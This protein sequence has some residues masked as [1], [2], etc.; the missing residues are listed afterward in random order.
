MF[1]T[2]LRLLLE[3]GSMVTVH[4][5]R[6][7]GKEVHRAG[8]F[9]WVRAADGSLEAGPD[10]EE[11]ARHSGGIWTGAGHPV[12][13]C[14][15]H[16]STCTARFESDN[17]D[18]STT[19]GPFDTVEFV[20]GSVYANPGC[21]LLARLDEQERTWYSYEDRRSWPRLVVENSVPDERPRCPSAGNEKKEAN[22]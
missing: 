16:G 20:D 2:A 19:H 12:P 7:D 15:I 9:P 11:V 10:G 22:G 5:L 21:R 6:T 8:P 13:K 1:G 18:D 17:P 3:F 14:I 4:F